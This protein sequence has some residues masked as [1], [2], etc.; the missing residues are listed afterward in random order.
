MPVF[1]SSYVYFYFKLKVLFMN[2]FSEKHYALAV[3]ICDV[4]S[5]VYWM[6]STSCALALNEYAVAPEGRSVL[7]TDCPFIC[8]LP[9]GLLSR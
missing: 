7:G 2:V 8:L 3:N 1:F 6:Q 4:D 5:Y 9:K